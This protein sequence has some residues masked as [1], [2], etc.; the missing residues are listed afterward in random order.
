MPAQ[1]EYYVDAIAKMDRIFRYIEK[2]GSIEFMEIVNVLEIS[3]SS[4]HRL[5]S[6]LTELGYLEKS[7]GG[8]IEL[9]IRLFELGYKMGG[10]I[11]I[12]KASRPYLEKLSEETGFVVHLGMLNSDNDGIFLDRIDS[13]S[14]TFTDTAIG[15]KMA[16]HCSAAGK[17]L[18]AWLPVERIE[19]IVSALEY[20][21]FT[22]QT[23][24]TAENF[25]KELALTR[26]RGYALDNMEH[27]QFIKAIGAP[28]FNWEGKVA[29]AVSIGAFQTEYDNMD[30]DHLLRCTKTATENIGKVIGTK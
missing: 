25:T 20:T 5:V 23:I 28:I 24:A 8:Q 21:V 10:N 6:Y 7:G 29:G 16:L 1:P 12:I 22:P 15:G 11:S 19:E 3:K 17:A 26:S 9:G 30:F 14:Y 18:L 4:A 13:R 2:K 27:E